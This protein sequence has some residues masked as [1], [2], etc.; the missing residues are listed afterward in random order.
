MILAL[1]FY[2]MQSF[3]QVWTIFCFFGANKV[4]LM[5][6]FFTLFIIADI[7]PISLPPLKAHADIDFMHPYEN[8]EGII[9][10]FGEHTSSGGTR[11]PMLLQGFVRIIDDKKCKAFFNLTTPNHFCAQN[12]INRSNICN[13]DIGGSLTIQIERKEILVG[14]SSLVLQFCSDA[15]PS[16]YTRISMYREWIRNVTS[17]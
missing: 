2:Q 3:S 16:A 12:T 8:E 14:I 11:S 5:F 13:S 6:R 1:L 17:V 9:T 7:S 4:H 15:E 10:G